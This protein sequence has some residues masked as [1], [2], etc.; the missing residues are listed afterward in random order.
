MSFAHI[1]NAFLA[2]SKDHRHLVSYVPRSARQKSPI[3]ELR[4]IIGRTQR[5][6][7]YSLGISPSALKRI[8][9]NDLALSPR[10]ARK[11]FYE[12]AVHPRSLNGKLR[13]LLS[14][15]GKPYTLEFYKKWK[16][17]YP[18]QDEDTA[19]V[20]AGNL[21]S[22]TE[23]LLRASVVGSKKRMWLV[24]TEIAETLDRCRVD[25]NLERPI[26]A[27]LARQRPPIKWEDLL[28]IPRGWPREWGMEKATASRKPR[29]SSRRGR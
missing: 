7:A 23:I 19:K 8:E 29:F 27:I 6:F 26:A 12:T 13:T 5:E 10:V 25:F 9:N 20:A 15:E 17:N 18:R 22:P 16:E 14:L 24:F 3:R 2:V 4:T 28:K 21:S 11:I 1:S